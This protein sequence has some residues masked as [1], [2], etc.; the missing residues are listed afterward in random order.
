MV[1]SPA[2]SF[3]TIEFISDVHFSFFSFGRWIDNFR[4]FMSQPRIVLISS[5]QPSIMVFIAFKIGCLLTFWLR[6]GRK[7]ASRIKGIAF[8]AFLMYFSKARQI[9]IMSSMKTSAD[10]GFA[11]S[12]QVTDERSQNLLSDK[13]RKRGIR[14]RTNSECSVTM[15]GL[16]RVLGPC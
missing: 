14:P 7:I 15:S 9:M 12:R 1:N 11:F 4:V 16:R 8:V 10:S 3:E 6:I 2:K 13:L 5:R